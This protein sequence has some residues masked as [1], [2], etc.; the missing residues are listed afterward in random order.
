[1]YIKCHKCFSQ[2]IRLGI[3]HVPITA[4]RNLN[5]VRLHF[6]YCFVKK[7]QL[8]QKLKGKAIQAA[9]QSSKLNFFP[10]EEKEVNY[11]V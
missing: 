3:H 8:V 2:L 1:M 5:T 7:S 6:Y 4:V 9:T 10:I 11:K